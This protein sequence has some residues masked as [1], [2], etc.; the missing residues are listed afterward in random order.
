MSEWR[1]ALW[2]RAVPGRFATVVRVMRRRSEE[3]LMPSPVSVDVRERVVTA[4]AEGASC[5]RAATTPRTASEAHADLILS[6]DADQPEIFL[7]E[8]RD[9]LAG[10]G[11]RTGTSGLWRFFR[12]H[13]IT[14]KRGGPRSCAGAAGREGGPPGL[15]RGSTRPRSRRS[16][17]PRRDRRHHEVSPALRPGSARCTMPDVRAEGSLQ[18]HDRYRSFAHPWPHRHRPV[19]WSHAQPTTA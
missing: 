6:T 8:L 18:D 12:R 4:V 19:R 10:H 3:R 14:R 15:V 2:A 16:G 13:R 17:V 5:P 7:R 11:G 1:D 9:R